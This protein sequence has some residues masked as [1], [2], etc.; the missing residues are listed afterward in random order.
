LL[1]LFSRWSSV[2]LSLFQC[3]P[4]SKGCVQ[5][6]ARLVHQQPGSELVLKP[7][8]VLDAGTYSK[9]ASMSKVS[10]DVL[11]EGIAGESGAARHMRA[12]HCC[13]DGHFMLPGGK[14]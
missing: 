3:L 10:S 9:S 1:L 13:C 8:A 5:V 14:A 11:K 7:V 12:G 2:C 6:S 4:D